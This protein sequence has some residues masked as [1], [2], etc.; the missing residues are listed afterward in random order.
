MNFILE[1]WAMF[2]NALKLRS[3]RLLFILLIIFAILLLSSCGQAGNKPGNKPVVLRLAHFFPKTHPAETELVAGWAKEIEEA[4]GGAVKIESYENETLLKAADIYKG[5]ID[6]IAD[7]GLSCFSYT[8]GSFPMLEVFELPGIIYENSYSASMTAWEAINHLDPEEIKDTKLMMVLAT[9]S[10]DL[11]MREPVKALED[12]NGKIIRATGASAPTIT[13][14]GATPEA[15]SQADAYE[16]LQKNMVNGNLG[17]IEVLQTWNHADFCKYIT[18]TPFLYNTLFFITMN[19][20]KWNSLP[21][22]IQEKILA[23]NEEYQEKV[24]AGLWDKQNEVALEWAKNEKGIEV[25]EL[26]EDEM[27]R[28]IKQVEK[29]QE[30]VIN[31]NKYI[32]SDLIEYVKE[33]ADKYNK[34]SSKD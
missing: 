33:L 29:V 18:K 12:L 34:M 7:I 2:S 4:T 1:G 13:A 16:A 8:P 9:G 11:F 19:L 22:D 25:L 21:S 30:D 5:V 20:N 15:M 10:G 23:V 24:A 14:L 17:P 28:W 6:G 26:P 32:D 31:K 27:A 3:I